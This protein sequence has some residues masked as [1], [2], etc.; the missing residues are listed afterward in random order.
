M[1]LLGLLLPLNQ[2]AAKPRTRV[3]FCNQATIKLY[4]TPVQNITKNTAF[5]ALTPKFRRG[6]KACQIGKPLSLLHSSGLCALEGEAYVYGQLGASCYGVF[7]LV[8]GL[9]VCV[10]FITSCA[11]VLVPVV[12]VAGGNCCIKAVF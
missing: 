1:P 8:V 3:K 9:G 10:L 11:Y 7:L 6:K 5:L 2:I 4:L 12:A